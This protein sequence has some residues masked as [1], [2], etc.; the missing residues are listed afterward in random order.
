MKEIRSCS[1]IQKRFCELKSGKSVKTPGGVLPVVT[2]IIL[3]FNLLTFQLH[4]I[5][6]SNVD[7][8]LE[9]FFDPLHVPHLRHWGRK[10]ALSFAPQHAKVVKRCSSVV[11]AETVCFPDVPFHYLPAVEISHVSDV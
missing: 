10:I 5:P 6:D 1:L 7:S 11:R 2:A 4:I 9:P 3:N 8:I